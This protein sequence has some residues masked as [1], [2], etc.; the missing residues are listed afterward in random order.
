MYKIQIRPPLGCHLA[1]PHSS[2]Y[3]TSS[4]RDQRHPLH[5]IKIL[6]FKF[7]CKSAVL[8]LLACIVSIILSGCGGLVWNPGVLGSIT[9][10]PGTVKFGPVMLGKKASTRVALANQSSSPITISKIDVSGPSFSLDQGNALPL[11][12]AAGST[13][14]VN[15]HFVPDA[16]GTQTGKVTIASNSTTSPKA[17]VSLTGTG[18][19]SSSPALSAISCGTQLLAG[20]QSKACS[21]YLSAPAVDP[22]VVY[23]KSNNAAVVVPTAVT[24]GTGA[25][26]TGFNTITAAIN[27]AQSVTL[28]ANAGGVSQTTSIQLNPD[29]SQPTTGHEVKLTWD[30]PSSAPKPIN[31]YHVYRSGG[32]TS[33]YRLLS[34]SIVSQTAY[35]DTTVQS[36]LSYNYVVKS[37]DNTG[38]ESSP[39]NTTSVAIP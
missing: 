7:N 39:S 2:P 13:L 11:T 3:Q 25:T 37:V 32:G 10:T 30:P 20:L 21:V 22:F 28:T 4:Q 15:V 17:V 34:S 36:G 9:P 16:T 1:T 14:S 18:S 19:T 31:G 38:S 6:T 29:P 23:L 27:T 33:Y 8:P 5:F 35:S 24:V 12:L 26:T